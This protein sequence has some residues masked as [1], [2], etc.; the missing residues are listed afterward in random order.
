MLHVSL[1]LSTKLREQ[2]IKLSNTQE[3]D[4]H[5]CDSHFIKFN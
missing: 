4:I 5:T 1:K 3:M 2:D